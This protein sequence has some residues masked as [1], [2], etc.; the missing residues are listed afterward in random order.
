MRAILA[1]DLND[2]DD[3]AKWNV[4]CKAECFYSAL[5]AMLE[6]VRRICKH[7]G[8]HGWQL[9]NRELELM[10]KVREEFWEI[11]KLKGIDSCF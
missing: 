9:T 4:Q 6:S 5:G 2:A 11:L 10:E 7:G 1:F 3:K 8:F